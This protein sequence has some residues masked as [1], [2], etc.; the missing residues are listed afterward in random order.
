MPHVGLW[1]GCRNQEV[2]GHPTF[3]FVIGAEFQFALIAAVAVLVIA[4]PC[5]LG[6]ATPTAI[7]VGTGK[8]A[9]KGILIKGGE[10]LESAHKII[11]LV[12]DKTG[13]ITKGTPEVTDVIPASNSKINQKKLL[14]IAA[15]LE[16][17]SEHPLAEAIVKRAKNSI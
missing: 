16:K 7:M 1:C 10:A 5:A 13:T 12:L 4:C 3:S 15:S 17:N 8:G 6:L 2:A 14:N 11:S 9:R